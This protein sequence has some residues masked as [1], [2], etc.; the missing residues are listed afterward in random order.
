MLIGFRKNCFL[1]GIFWYNNLLEAAASGDAYLAFAKQ[2]GM[3]PPDATKELHPRERAICK[4]L[5]LG[6]L[7]AWVIDASASRHRS[8]KKRR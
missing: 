6:G 2:I 5:T 8:Q 3:V 1:P 7:T 4:I